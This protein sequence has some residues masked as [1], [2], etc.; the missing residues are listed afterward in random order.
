[1]SGVICSGVHHGYLRF[2]VFGKEQWAGEGMGR[3]KLFLPSIHVP[4]IPVLFPQIHSF[5]H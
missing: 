3:H 2:I 5:L 1:M 4:F